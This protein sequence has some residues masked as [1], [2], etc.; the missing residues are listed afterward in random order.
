MPSPRDIQPTV[1]AFAGRRIDTGG[2]KAAR[3][4]FANVC[5][6]RAAIGASLEGIAPS[7]LIASAACGADLIALEA[8]ANRHIRM[9]FC[10]F[11]RRGFARPRWSTGRIQNSGAGSMTML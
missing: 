5:A 8:A 9:R 11:P 4:P 2:A 3:F 10:L 7:L 1:V 6:V